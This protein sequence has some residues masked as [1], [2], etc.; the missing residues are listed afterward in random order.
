MSHLYFTDIY[1][2]FRYSWRFMIHAFG[3]SIIGHG[4]SA[5]GR[6]RTD[7]ARIVTA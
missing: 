6:V 7:A 4:P 5:Q 2:R 1:A 3:I